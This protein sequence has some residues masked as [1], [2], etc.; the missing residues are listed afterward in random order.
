M[1]LTNLLDGIKHNKNIDDCEVVNIT[2]NS[3]TVVPGSAFV[4]VPGKNSDGHDYAF[5]ALEKG[6]AVVVAQRDLGLER[7]VIVDNTAAAYSLMSANFFGRPAEKLRLVGITG[8]NGKTTT[9][10][11]LKDILEAEGYRVGLIGT[12]SN[13]IAGVEKPALLTTPEPFEL[14]RL[15]AEMVEAG[16]QFAIM[17]V[18]SQALEQERVAGCRFEAGIFTNLTQD[19]LDYHGNMENYRAAKKRLFEISDNAVINIDDSNARFMVEGLSCNVTT[20]SINTDI[21]DY[22]AKNL[23]Y[24]TNGVD[25]ELLG[26]GVIGRVKLKL[27]GSFSVYNAMAAAS[28]ALALGV[29]FNNVIASLSEAKGVKGRLE[30]VPTNRDFTVVID[31]AHTPDGLEKVLRALKDTEPS[32]LVALFGCGGDRDAKKRPLMGKVAA[33]IA[34]FVVVT[35][36][37]PRTEEPGA[38]IQDILKGMED[39]E[40]PYVVIEDRRQAIKYAIDNAMPGDV[41]VLAGKGHETYQ[42]IG[43]EKLHF[44]EREVVAEALAGELEV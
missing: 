2:N 21:A 43:K 33:E 15:F 29:P 34:D 1:R 24:H 37:N 8:T 23:R 30:V 38:I 12:I 6:A 31:Y 18:S 10:Y 35:S 19:H 11:L 16:C 39:T 7:Q 41:I 26:R 25:F 36:D 44:D 9:S 5:E 28:C 22:T 40:T 4:C 17:E 14:Q 20:Y 3:R 42:I 27:M 32:R 13:F